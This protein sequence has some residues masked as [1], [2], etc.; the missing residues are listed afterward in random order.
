LLV[1]AALSRSPAIV[2]AAPLAVDYRQLA[3]EMFG[4]VE[5]PEVSKSRRCELL[6]SSSCPAG[7]PIG[8]S[9]GCRELGL[10]GERGVCAAV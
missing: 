3:A 7:K 8:C 5:E 6:L 9:L 1:R 2:A 10:L 4:Q